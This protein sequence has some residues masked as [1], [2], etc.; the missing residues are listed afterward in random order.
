ML[1]SKAITEF[2]IKELQTKG[3]SDIAFWAI[4]GVLAAVGIGA[5]GTWFLAKRGVILS[6][7][8]LSAE[9]EGVDLDNRAKYYDA[10]SKLKGVADRLVT[11]RNDMTALLGDIAQLLQANKKRGLRKARE[12][13]CN[14]YS[15]Q[16]LE[17][18][19]DYLNECPLLL[20]RQDCYDRMLSEAIPA[21]HN[22]KKL[23]RTVNDSRLLTRL[24]N[25][26][27]LLLRKEAVDVIFQRV[28]RRIPFIR[29][30][31]HHW[32]LI[33]LRWAMKCHVRTD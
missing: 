12:D 10:A 5:A 8:K 9:A 23:V 19:K 4:I 27:K 20:N 14:F 29:G 33:R 7:L 2:L 28:R 21:L 30:C 24:D 11:D 15:A 1:D 25:P 17:T 6:N 16:Y 32:T 26:A 3:L 22:M 13:L 31:K 18:L